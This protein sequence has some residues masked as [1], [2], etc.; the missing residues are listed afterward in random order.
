D[1]KDYR[2]EN[3]INSKIVKFQDQQ[4]NIVDQIPALSHFAQIIR[5]N[6]I[7]KMHEFAQQADMYFKTYLYNLAQKEHVG[8]H[9][10][11][12]KQKIEDRDIM[13]HDF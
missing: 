1:H 2:M 13:I 6:S 3:E 4:K 5:K 7:C 12:I 11:E 8:T 9:R 10:E